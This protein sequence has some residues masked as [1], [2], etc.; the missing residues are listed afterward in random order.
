MIENWVDVWRQKRLKR[1]WWQKYKETKLLQV[2]QA[3][4]LKYCDEFKQRG[5]LRTCFKAFKL[6]SQFA[7]TRLLERKLKNKITFE[8]ESEYKTKKN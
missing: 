7:G 5:L 8:V 6:Y 4:Q 3:K 2:R 1:V